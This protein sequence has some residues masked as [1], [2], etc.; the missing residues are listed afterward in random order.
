[1]QAWFRLHNVLIDLQD[2]VS[3]KPINYISDDNFKAM[4]HRDTIADFL[5]HVKVNWD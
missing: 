3:I 4:L 2:D 5:K 1:M